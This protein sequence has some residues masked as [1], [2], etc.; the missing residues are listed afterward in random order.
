RSRGAEPRRDANAGAADRTFPRYGEQVVLVEQTLR[1]ALLIGMSG[2]A[3][4]RD[5]AIQP[6]IVRRQ[7]F[8]AFQLPSRLDPKVAQVA[9]TCA[10][11][12]RTTH[13]PVRL[14]H[15]R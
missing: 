15:L 14:E 13:R 2:K 3:Q 12:D 10:F 8:H 4:S 9:Q 7:Y 5:P 1:H 6:W 11:G